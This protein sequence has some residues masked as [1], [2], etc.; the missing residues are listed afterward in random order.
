MKYL[1]FLILVSNNIFSTEFS[2][3]QERG[4][5]D[6]QELDENSG[7]VVG[8]N[9][10]NIIWAV[11]DGASNEI[12]GFDKFGKKTLI[13]KFKKNIL[14]ENTDIEDLALIRLNN[15][16][17]LVLPDIGDNN[18]N[19]QKCYIYFVPEPK[20]GNQTGVLNIDI[21]NILK[22]EFEY[23][24]GPRD[25]ECFLAD[26]ISNNFY[27]V[28]KRE[29]KARLYSIPINFNNGHLIAEYILEFP[30][31]NNGELGFTGVTAG[32]ISKEGNLILIKDYN[33][34]WLYSRTGNEDLKYTFS[35]PPIRIDSYNYSLSKEPQG[36][37]ICW[38]NY[39]TGFFTASEEK[40]I[41]NFDASLY[42]FEEIQTSVIIENEQFNI[43][44][45][46]LYSKSLITLNLYFYNYIGQ[47]IKN[48]K[49][50]PSNSIDLN[51]YINQ[52]HY[53]ILDNINSIIKLR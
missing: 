35:K 32:D 36:E 41:P 20:I 28:T 45:N 4:I 13:I 17:Y 14:D 53:L 8:S 27:I 26:P 38:E 9:N 40:S 52:A 43:Q 48:E 24:D 22:L 5:I 46:I 29:K 51:K 12:F 21:D 2:E 3:R 42:Y 37:S 6:Y 49:L 15:N 10:P 23:E 7:M 30:F 18:S 39:N 25:A 19:K 31:G 11:N 50:S 44:D 1:L 33:N 34:V 16:P 47:L